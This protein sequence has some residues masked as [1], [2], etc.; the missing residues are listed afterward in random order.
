MSIR[1]ENV[2]VRLLADLTFKLF[3]SVGVTML[4]VFQ[5]KFLLQPMLE[6]FVV[7]EA[8]GAVTLAATQ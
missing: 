5:I 7:D 6:A 3:P 1:A 4:F 8:H 2:G